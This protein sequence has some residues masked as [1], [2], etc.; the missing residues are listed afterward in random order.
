MSLGLKSREQVR[1][2]QNASAVETGL[3]VA[4]GIPVYFVQSRRLWEQEHAR[5]DTDGGISCGDISIG[6]KLTNCEA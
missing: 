1:R 3:L 4:L 2:P 5:L 6:G